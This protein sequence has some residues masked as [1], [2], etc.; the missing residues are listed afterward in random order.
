MKLIYCK[1]CNKNYTRYYI[2]S[3]LKSIKHLNKSGCDVEKDGI[4]IEKSLQFI[5]KDVILTFK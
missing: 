3:H 4:N 1:A 5:K 2:N